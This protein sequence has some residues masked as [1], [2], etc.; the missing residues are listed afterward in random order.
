MSRQVENPVT[1]N[2]MREILKIRVG[3]VHGY[4][5]SYV[6]EEQD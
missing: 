4:W 1:T 5:H 6:E 2:C 3:L